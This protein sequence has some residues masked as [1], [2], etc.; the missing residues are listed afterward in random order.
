M[1]HIPINRWVHSIHMPHSHDI[2]LRMG[3]VVHDERFWPIMAMVIFLAIIV[4]L[5]IL[6]AF[7]GEGGT[8]TTPYVPSPLEPFGPFMP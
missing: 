3:H 8:E 7:G 4:F 2:G 6:G 1:Y 5:A